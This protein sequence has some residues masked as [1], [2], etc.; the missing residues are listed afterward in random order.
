VEGNLSQL[1]SQ[2][3]HR[4]VR[5]LAWIIASPPLVSGEIDGVHWWSHDDCLAEFLDCLPALQDLDKYPQPLI[6]YLNNLKNRRLG[7]IFEAYINFWL[8]L[9][10]NYKVIERNLQIIENNHTYGEVDFIMKELS[11]K[12]IIHLEVAVKFYLGSSPYEDA[13]RWF[14]TN[15]RDQLGKKIDHLRTQQTQLS[16]RYPSQLR[17][18]CDYSIDQRHCFIKGRLFY[19]LDSEVSPQNFPLAKNH[20][21]GRWC[22]VNNRNTSAKMIKIN[23]IDWLA[24]YNHIDIENS[25]LSKDAEIE[26]IDRAE[27]FIQISEVANTLIEMERVFYLPQSF[28]F[29]AQDET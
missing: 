26:S 7:S 10:P 11:T 5:D 13:Y 23:K 18:Y 12:K 19:S 15:T 28:I 3:K 27:C 6:S 21:R 2:F 24:E 9:S 20:L 1:L 14:G 4:S 22:Y 8:G 25:K 29:P 16:K 17:K